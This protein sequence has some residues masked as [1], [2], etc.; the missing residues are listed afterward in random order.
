MPL[1]CDDFVFRKV[2]WP[3]PLRRGRWVGFRLT[4]KLPLSVTKPNCR[5]SLNC[6]RRLLTKKISFFLLSSN[7]LS[8]QQISYRFAISFHRICKEIPIFLYQNF[9]FN[10][11]FK[12]FFSRECKYFFVSHFSFRATFLLIIVNKAIKIWLMVQ[13]ISG[14][15][16]SLYFQSLG[17]TV[18]PLIC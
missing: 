11:N 9:S 13:N 1:E 10:E 6:L 14:E 17:S 7:F 5:R 18:H 12:L 2:N 8:T 4:A 16:V 15:N 3:L